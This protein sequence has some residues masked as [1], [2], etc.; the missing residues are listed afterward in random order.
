MGDLCLILLGLFEDL[1]NM[2]ISLVVL[3]PPPH[4]IRPTLIL[5]AK[6]RV[7]VHLR[8]IIVGR[9]RCQPLHHITHLRRI[10]MVHEIS[11]VA[12]PWVPRSILGHAQVDGTILFSSE[13]L[14]IDGKVD[15][16]A[17]VAAT[18][19]WIGFGASTVD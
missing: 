7:V 8:N 12:A 4:R 13:L 5:G 6:L 15:C 19:G 1:F 17:R 3:V 14:A 18:G 11:P 9:P 2:R 10:P 16:G